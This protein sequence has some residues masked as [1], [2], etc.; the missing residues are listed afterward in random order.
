MEN[1]LDNMC[2]FVSRLQKDLFYDYDSE[3]TDVKKE[4]DKNKQR[5]R[6]SKFLSQLVYI[7]CQNQIPH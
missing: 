2:V 3:E 6:Q 5:A 1:L 4:E 7:N